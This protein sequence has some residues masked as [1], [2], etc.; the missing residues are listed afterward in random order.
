M[1]HR[2]L[3]SGLCAAAALAAVLIV[4][5][6]LPLLE[7]DPKPDQS[8]LH[9]MIRIPFRRSDGTLW[10][11]FGVASSRGDLKIRRTLYQLMP[12]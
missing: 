11:C 10:S 1:L 3:D 2:I 8:V 12:T 9:V 5:D 7:A 6:M 4:D